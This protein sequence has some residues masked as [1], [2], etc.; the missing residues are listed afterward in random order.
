M[1][2]PAGGGAVRWRAGAQDGDGRL[3]CRV[4]KVKW[5]F[6]MGQR[7]GVGFRRGLLAAGREQGDSGGMKQEYVKEGEI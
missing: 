5:G 2:L 7:R 6:V 3:F 1:E 4:K